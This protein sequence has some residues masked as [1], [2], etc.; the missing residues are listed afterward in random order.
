M[1][2]QCKMGDRAISHADYQSHVNTLLRSHA[3]QFP[4]KYPR[5]VGPIHGPLLQQMQLASTL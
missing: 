1:E 5:G 3:N 4:V 2:K